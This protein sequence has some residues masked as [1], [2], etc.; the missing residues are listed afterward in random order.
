MCSYCEKQVNA[1]KNH[2]I[3]KNN[4]QNDDDEIKTEILINHGWK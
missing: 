3:C 2:V 1:Q 4:N